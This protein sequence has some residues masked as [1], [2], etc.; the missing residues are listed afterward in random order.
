MFISIAF[1]NE[2]NA[3]KCGGGEN[4]NKSLISI[5]VPNLAF[6]VGVPKL[7]DAFTI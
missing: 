6:F 7:I 1:R 4:K 2:R 3:M 5:R